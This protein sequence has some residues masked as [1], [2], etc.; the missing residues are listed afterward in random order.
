MQ[1]SGKR[2]YEAA[3]PQASPQPYAFAGTTPV[4]SKAARPNR[5]DLL[6]PS[7]AHPLTANLRSPS[8]VRRPLRAARA[9]DA[10]G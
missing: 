8:L 7:I 4:S 5:V 10:R 6:W 3:F 1:S 2:P 9:R